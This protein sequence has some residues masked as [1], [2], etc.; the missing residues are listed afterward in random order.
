MS[1]LSVNK[2]STPFQKLASTTPGQFVKEHTG[3]TAAAGLGSAV[4]AKHVAD[5]SD[6]AAKVLEKGAVPVLGAGAAVLGATMVHDAFVQGKQAFASDS[7]EAKAQRSGELGKGLGGAA[8]VLAGSEVAARPFG[9]SPLRALGRVVQH[10]LGEAAA[11]ALPGLGAA[12]WG[13]ADMKQNGVT[14]ANSAA[15]GLGSTWTAFAT[16]IATMDYSPMTSEVAM[17]T[18]SVAGGAGLGLGAVALGKKAYESLQDGNWS[19]TALYA[20]GATAAGVA[21]AHVLGNA[22]GVAALSN[23]AGKAFKNP[24]LAGSIAVVGLTGVAYVAYSHQKD[25]EAAKVKPEGSW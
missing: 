2:A 17:K 6:L 9:V 8:L 16:G 19:K 25:A 11:L 7:K 22:S 20:G 10:P 13:A 18:A 5:H 15:L 4:I 21:S 23:L 24:L 12:V 14:I 3:L 1:N